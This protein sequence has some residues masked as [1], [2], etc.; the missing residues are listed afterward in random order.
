MS[1]FH[2]F[3][4]FIFLALLRAQG[5]ISLSPSLWPLHA[6]G[7]IL[8]GPRCN[9]NNK[10]ASL[11]ACFEFRTQVLVARNLVDFFELV[12]LECD[13]F[14]VEGQ[15]A[16]HTFRLSNGGRVAWGIQFST[17]Y[18]ECVEGGLLDLQGPFGMCSLLFALQKM[19]PLNFFN[20]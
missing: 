4:V 2:V 13:D 1:P 18:L 19:G 10:S 16:L 11:C 9:Y 7:H 12:I 6:G 20:S 17:Q 14:Q 8:R 15:T 5:H 3:R